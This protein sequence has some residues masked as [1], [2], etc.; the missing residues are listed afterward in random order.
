[1]EKLTSLCKRRGF[2]FPS[3]EIYGGLNG[4]W[5][6]GPLGAEMKRNIKD[7]W[8]KSMV[9]DRDDIVGIDSSIVAHPRV[10]EASGHVESF[11]DPMVDCKRCKARFRADKLDEYRADTG[12]KTFE[13]GCPACGGELTEARKFNLMFKTFV[14]PVED[15]A[16]VAF[17]R[18]ETCQSIFVNFKQVQTVSR[19]KVPFGIAQ[20]GKSFRNEVTPRNFIFRSREFEQMEMEFFCDPKDDQRWF[21]HWVQERFN[22]YVGLGIRKEKLRLRQQTPDELAH[23]AKAA[24]DV[25]YEFPFGWQELEGIAHRGSYDLEQ[26]S[27]CSGKDLSYF[28]DESKQHFVPVVIEPSAGVDRTLLTMLVDA[29][30]E[31]KLENEEER[32]V[33]HLH[34]KIAPIQVGVFPLSKKLA[35]PVAALEK[36]LRNEFRTFYDDA[37]AIGRRYRRQDEIGTPYCVTYDF[38]SQNDN[39]VTVRERDSMKQERIPI[40]KLAELLRE[41]FA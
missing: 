41:K 30:D 40:E 28:D 16:S 2:I 31:E 33:L 1:M 5:D 15:A 9:H 4:F 29:F 8:W 17:L 14:G 7:A 25:E 38:E 23:Y 34:P 3:S 13:T 39:A 36:R 35:E 21:D 19:R 10:W 26:H 18:P 22:W 24:F 11:A 32:V 12:K 20:M 6:Y 37:G 27:R